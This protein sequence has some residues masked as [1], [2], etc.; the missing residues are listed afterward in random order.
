MSRYEQISQPCV[1]YSFG[2]R[3]ETS[4]EKSILERTECELYGVDFS[5]SNFSREVL[6][7]SEI[8]LK[9]AKFLQAGISEGET[10]L[11]RSPPFYSIKVSM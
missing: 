1:V 5:V 4:F 2:V 8:D 3:D 11:G 10:D 7:L 6:S 9:R